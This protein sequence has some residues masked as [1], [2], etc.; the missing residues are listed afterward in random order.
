VK[1]HTNSIS[2]TFTRKYETTILIRYVLKIF[3]EYN[4]LDRM[5][6]DR[7][8]VLSQVENRWET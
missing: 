2:L 7:S 5:T 4:V 3:N 8:N 1:Y 6:N